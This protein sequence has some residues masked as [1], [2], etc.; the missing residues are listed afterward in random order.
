MRQKEYSLKELYA[1]RQ[2]CFSKIPSFWPTVVA[3]GPEEL[4]AVFA[5]NDAL[6]LVA[7]KSM[8]VERHQIKSDT[9]GEP[10]SLRFTF[11]F[12]KND[13]F[14]DSVVVKDFDFKVREDGGALVSTPVTFH[15]TSKAKKAG[16]NKLLDLADQLYKAEKAFTDGPIDQTERENL[17]QYEKLR[18]ELE[19]QQEESSDEYGFLDW[20]GFRGAVNDLL[21]KQEDEDI[22]E[23]GEDL[24]DGTLEVEIFPGG[25]DIAMILAEDLWPDAVEYFI[26]AQED[27]DDDIEIDEEEEDDDVVPE[28]VQAGDFEEFDENEDQ[29]PPTKK[30]RR[31]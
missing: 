2:T 28:L 5:P 29:K 23:D 17:W 18:E 13:I 8:K 4:Q 24:D 7:L 21:A 19:K 26:R 10:R 11:E 20:F 6:V 27:D 15:W 14:E 3:N 25:E 1:K 30:A 9:E 22:D 31:S 16:T 12:D